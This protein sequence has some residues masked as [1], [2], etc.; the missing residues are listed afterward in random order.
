MFYHAVSYNN[1]GQTWAGTES[2]MVRLISELRT[3]ENG[4]RH[5]EIF[6]IVKGRKSGCFSGVNFSCWCSFNR[7]YTDC[8]VG[9]GWLGLELQLNINLTAGVCCLSNF[10]IFLAI[11]LPVS[12]SVPG[13]KPVRPSLV[14][15]NIGSVETFFQDVVFG[16]RSKLFLVFSF[17]FP[18]Y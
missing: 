17:S 8:T 2:I 14:N 3:I 12:A 16:A 7:Y 11:I 9:F 10:V 5:G 15:P 4:R 6:R 13:W 1:T 18:Y